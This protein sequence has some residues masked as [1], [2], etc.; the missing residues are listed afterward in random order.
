M[1]DSRLVFEGN[2]LTIYPT[3]GGTTTETEYTVDTTHTPR[4]IDLTVTVGR[5]GLEKGQVVKGIYAVDGNL[6]TAD[7]GGVNAERPTSLSDKNRPIVYY[8]RAGT[9]VKLPPAGVSPRLREL[10]QQRVKALQL[11][12]EGQFERVKIGKDPLIHLMNV[13]AEL[14][15]AEL[16]LAETHEQKVAAVERMLK[17]LH[18]V[19]KQ[20]NELHAAGLHTLQG[21]AHAKAARLKA[22]VQ[23]EKLKAG[24]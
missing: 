16:D 19:E 21:V 2:R 14:S 18:E 5:A 20:I 8:R 9:D 10:Q 22:E 15:E 6:L 4:H 1:S 11:Q 24:Q 3:N 7:F 17:L 13:I 12:L 23:L